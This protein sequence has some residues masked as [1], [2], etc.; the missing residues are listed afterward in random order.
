MARKIVFFLLMLVSLASWGAE[1]KLKEGSRTATLKPMKNYWISSDCKKCEA[2]KIMD[3]M[4]PLDIKKALAKV[5]DGRISPGTRVCNG[6]GG[7]SWALKDDQG[8]TFSICE[9][10]D[11][12]YVL[13]DDLAGLIPQTNP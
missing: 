8:R 5:P 3:T 1:M 13:T 6:L 10:K 4:K 7:M 12:S 11:K 9:F 2:Q